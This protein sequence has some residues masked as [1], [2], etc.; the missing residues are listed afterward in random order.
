MNFQK[1]DNHQEILIKL[2]ETTELVSR[3]ILKNLFLMTPHFLSVYIET[4][5]FNLTF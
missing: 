4:E 1:K 5:N 2:P 3:K